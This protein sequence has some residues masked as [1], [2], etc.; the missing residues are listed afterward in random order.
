MRFI[1]IGVHY[2]YNSRKDMSCDEFY[3]VFLLYNGGKL[4]A[5]G[6]AFNAALT[7]NRVEHPPKSSIA[8]C[9]F[10]FNVTSLSIIMYWYKK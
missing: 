3:P 6:W 8:V 7:S 4:N 1:Q 9:I 5:F 10:S 2:W